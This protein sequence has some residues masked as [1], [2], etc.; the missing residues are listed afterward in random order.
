MGD[1]DEDGLN[2]G[3]G[4]LSRLANDNLSDRSEC[5]MPLALGRPNQNQHTDW[6]SR[7][8]CSSA[9][10][11]KTTKCFAG[12]T[13]DNPPGRLQ[14]FQVI[15]RHL[16]TESNPTPALYRM[17]IFAPNAVIAKSRF[18]YFLRGLQKVK[19]TTGEIVSVNAVRYPAPV[20]W[21]E[22]LLT[23]P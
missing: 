17:R 11:P 4:L 22:Q 18:W 6:R 23:S 13:T 5:R 14:E 15:G 3:T 10:A 12:I 1:Y 21:L 16:P 8:P 20:L 2:S 7:R 9:L 19:K